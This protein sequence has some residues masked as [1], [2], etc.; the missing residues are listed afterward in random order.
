ML[1]IATC[2]ATFVGLVLALWFSKSRQ[3]RVALI[4]AASCVAAVTV[5][6]VL[7]WFTRDRVTSE[8]YGKLERDMTRDQVRALLGEP[9][10]HS[11]GDKWRQASWTGAEGTISVVFIKGRLERAVFEPDLSPPSGILDQ[12]RRALGF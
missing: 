7:L 2:I 10:K 5:L 8:N 11:G 12:I 9:H 1:Y 4:C 6:L 3:R